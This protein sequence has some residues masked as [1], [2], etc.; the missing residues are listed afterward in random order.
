MQE[1]VQLGHELLGHARVDHDLHGLFERP[2]LI[3]A[4]DDLAPVREL[5]RL[6]QG[7]LVDHAHGRQIHGLLALLGLGL[8]DG[9]TRLHDVGELAADEVDAAHGHRSAGHVDDLLLDVEILEEADEAAAAVPDQGVDGP[10]L[11]PHQHRRALL[12]HLDG[13]GRDDAG[14]GVAAVHILDLARAV[15][16]PD[17]HVEG[18]EQPGR[19]G[20]QLQEPDAKR[21]LVGVGL[22]DEARDI[23]EVGRIEP[24]VLGDDDRGL[25]AHLQVA[26][27]GPPQL[28]DGLGD[29]ARRLG[30]G[31][32][33]EQLGVLE[34]PGHGER[35][36][37]E[38][39]GLLDHLRGEAPVDIRVRPVVHDPVALAGVPGQDHQADAAGV[40][41]LF[42][43]RG[44]DG[45]VVLAPDLDQHGLVLERQG[46]VVLRSVVL[47]AVPGR[48]AAGESG[49]SPRAHVRLCH[50]VLAVGQEQLGDAKALV[51]GALIQ[52][53]PLL[54][55][56]DVLDVMVAAVGHALDVVVFAGGRKERGY[57]QGHAPHLLRQRVEH[58]LLDHGPVGFHDLDRRFQRVR[59][60]FLIV[61]IVA[62][63][64]HGRRDGLVAGRGLHAR[65]RVSG[66]DVRHGPLDVGPDEPQRQRCRE[67]AEEHVLELLVHLALGPGQHI[68][69]HPAVEHAEPGPFIEAVLVELPEKPGRLRVALLRQTGQVVLLA[70]AVG[71]GVALRR[72]AEAHGPDD[73]V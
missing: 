63:G 44:V 72:R 56:V 54:R 17:Q 6:E 42:A 5:D 16:E 24:R 22:E 30:L 45:R 52:P 28:V 36:A 66:R 68:V 2:G 15:E 34:G 55:D 11:G 51:Q 12:K 31:E 64:R 69:R 53:E 33:P 29:V 39:E 20:R 27:D 23:G 49:R 14:R 19:R 65:H 3:H 8:D 41:E 25:E 47:S 70:P 26:D 59:L 21:R 9:R 37:P 10:D 1:L 38:Q 60:L 67:P 46:A 62:H 40:L 61:P 48:R 7:P 32:A 35:I 50:R 73:I 57:V 58:G 71:L 4:L 43:L 13:R 18:L